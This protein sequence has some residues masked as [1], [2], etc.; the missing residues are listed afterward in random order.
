MATVESFSSLLAQS[1]LSVPMLAA[2]LG[3]AFGFG[4]LHAMEPG[5]GKTMV[6][7]YLVGSRGTP[8]HAVL[9][10]LITTFTHTASVFLLG[11]VTLFLSQW[12]LPSTLT[13]ILGVISGL[14]ILIVGLRL[15]WQ[16]VARLR[17]HHHHHHGHSHGHDHSHAHTHEHSHAHAE[18]SAGKTSAAMHALETKHAKGH[19]HQHGHGHHH[20]HSHEH[21]HE[22]S[23]DH[24]HHG[25]EHHHHHDH[26]H[27]HEHHHMPEGAITMGSLIALGVSGGLVPCPSGLV[28][29]LSAVSLGR[30]GLGLVMLTAF[31]AGLA[32]VLTALGLIVLYAK[33]LLPE[34][35]RKSGWM[36][37]Y[38]PVASA[39]VI[40]A[41]GLLMTALAL[42]WMPEGAGLL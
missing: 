33:G 29:L 14:L 32:V 8:R 25:H 9:L 11:L 5:H 19:S 22:H 13:P 35:T 41:I 17:G 1:E 23:H 37:R 36:T 2:A 24:H 31:S 3:S 40:V 28:L 12:I 21:H 38:L 10:G 16:R 18:V 6:A 26:G 27:S 7:A 42:G 15:L 20:G 30:P 34:R 4:A 39:A